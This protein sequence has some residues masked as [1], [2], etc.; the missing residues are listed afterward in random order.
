MADTPRDDDP[1]QRG[2][3]DPN[4]ELERR[5]ERL[6]PPRKPP[7]EL[8]EPAPVAESIRPAIEHE[9]DPGRVTDTDRDGDEPAA[10]DDQDEQT[11]ERGVHPSLAAL[12]EPA[13][14]T[15]ALRPATE[16][17]ASSTD[18]ATEPGE[19]Q[20]VDSDTN[21]NDAEEEEEEV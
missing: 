15:N 14:V 9:A 8:N 7:E 3:R 6:R 12:N 10:S 4:E 13:P 18:P 21:D 1:D 11:S 19:S 20:T 17:I 2:D 16:Q 5:L